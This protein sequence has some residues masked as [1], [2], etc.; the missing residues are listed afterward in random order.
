M[1]KEVTVVLAGAGGYGEWHLKGLLAHEAE[2]G[3]RLTGVIDPHIERCGYLPDLQQRQIP[4]YPSLE[5]F[6]SRNHCDLMILCTPIQL[7]C[8][9]VVQALDHGSHVHC[10]KPLCASY[11]QI[12]LMQ[13]AEKNSGKV[14]SIG[15]QWSYSRAIQSLKTDILRGRL[16]CPKR[17]RCVIGWPRDETYYQRNQ[18]AGRKWSELGEPIFDSPVNNATAHFLHNMLYVLGPEIN[19][20]ARPKHVHAELW[21]ANPIEN[22]DTAALRIE[23][24]D[25]VEILFY[26]SHA[27]PVSLGPRFSYEFERAV[28]H[29]EA[30]SEQIKARFLSGETIDYGSPE[31]EPYQKL[32]DAIESARTNRPT[33]CGISAASAHTQCVL[34]AQESEQGIQNFPASSVKCIPVGPA[35]HWQVNGLADVMRQCY[36][37]G[38]I[39]S[40][41]D[42]MLFQ[43]GSMEP[44]VQAES[45]FRI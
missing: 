39:F 5:T 45:L 22:Y 34:L 13:A 9:Q 11:E 21:R 35:R 44:S 17:L 8:E 36:D 27:V 31:S 20:S 23:V 18:W 19:E 2:Q 37:E 33:V 30:E 10:E 38:I 40:E 15:Y 32:W 24:E 28:V 6:Y 26:T 3:F 1:R 43:A 42:A 29:Y 7:H 4:I 41:C 14:V 12:E 25:G 16:G